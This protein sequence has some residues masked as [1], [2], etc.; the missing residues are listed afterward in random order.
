MTRGGLETVWDLEACTGVPR[1]ASVEAHEPTRVSIGI[2]DS[3]AQLLE[4]SRPK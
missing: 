2:Q 3:V 4:K 1:A